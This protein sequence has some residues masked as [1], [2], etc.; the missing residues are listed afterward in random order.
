VGDLARIICT[1]QP[2]ASRH[3]AYLRKAKLVGSRNE[4][5]W[6][7]YSLDPAANP[8]HQKLLECLSHCFA[9]V[10]AIQADAARASMLKKSGGCCPR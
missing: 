2:T 6:T 8:F 5:T 3:L 9:E 1:P 7:F 10:P 4:G